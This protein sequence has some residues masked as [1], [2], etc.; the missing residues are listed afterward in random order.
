MVNLL[1]LFS[2]LLIAAPASLL[3]AAPAFAQIPG[4]PQNLTSTVSG[5]TVTLAWSAPTSGGA[6][7]GYLVEAALTPGGGLVAT[8]QVGGTSLVVPNVPSGVY[9]VRVRARNSSGSSAPS[10]EVTVNVAGGCPAPP[11]PPELVVRS[12]AFQGSATWGSSGGCAPTSYTLLVGSGPGL[13]NIVIVNAGSQTGLSTVAPPFVYYAR[14]I[15]TNAFGSAVSDE[16]IVRVAQN[17]QTDTIPVNDAVAFDVVITGTGTYRWTLV[18]NDPSIDLD[19]YLT[20]AGCPYPPGGCLVA[21]SDTTGTSTE[22][23]SAPVIAGQTYRLWIDNFSPRS[24]SFTI[25]TAIGASITASETG[26]AERPR[27]TKVK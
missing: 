23:I 2:I 8:L 17:A 5:S 22:T 19:L 4:T 14:V 12:V 1:R 18:W 11:L 7:T 10:N 25:F 21:I 24:T 6:P 15:G 13:S 20:T 27:I 9:Y 16:R 3:M 26:D